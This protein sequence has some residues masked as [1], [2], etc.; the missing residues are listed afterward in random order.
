[1]GQTVYVGIC[2]I[3]LCVTVLFIFAKMMNNF[4]KINNDSHLFNYYVHNRFD[5]IFLFKENA[6]KRNWSSREKNEHSIRSWMIAA[7]FFLWWL[8]RYFLFFD[9]FVKQRNMPTAITFESISLVTVHSHSLLREFRFWN[10][11]QEALAVGSDNANNDGSMSHLNQQLEQS[12]N[13]LSQR[14][15][16]GMLSHMLSIVIV[17]WMDGG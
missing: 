1:M 13:K 3:K 7:F 15:P 12:P 16:F 8:W 5:C 6:N 10:L 9:P 11:L 4:D 14:I 2:N 17:V